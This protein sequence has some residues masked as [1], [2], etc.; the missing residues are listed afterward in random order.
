MSRGNKVREQT[1]KSN[2]NLYASGRREQRG[3]WSY[4]MQQQMKTKRYEQNTK[5]QI[6]IDSNND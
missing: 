4:K 2:N 1:K 5:H 3:N 6:R